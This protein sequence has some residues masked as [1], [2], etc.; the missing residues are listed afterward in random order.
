M[1]TPP[2]DGDGPGTAP[3]EFAAAAAPGEVTLSWTAPDTGRPTAEYQLYVNERPTTV[4]QFGAGAA[5]PPPGGRVE[6]RLTVTEAVRHR[7]GRESAGPPAR[8][9][10][11]AF[12]AERRITLGG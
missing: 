5:V 9:Q 7:L 8:R 4:I 3:A 12:S 6:H 10:L 2:A 1:T 11:G